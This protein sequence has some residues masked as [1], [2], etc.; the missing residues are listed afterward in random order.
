V[1]TIFVR[2]QVADY[3]TWRRVFD[4]FAPTQKS[5]GVLSAD[6]YQATDNANDITVTHDFASPEVAQA[7]AASPE[8]RAAMH[9]AGVVG[10]PT[11][12]FTNRS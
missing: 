12:W 11:I 3:P 1:T 4:G 6:V 5:L 10:A 8:L 9:D 7:F 2:H